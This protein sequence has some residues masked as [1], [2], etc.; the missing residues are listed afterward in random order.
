MFPNGDFLRL[1]IYF[2]LWLFELLEPAVHVGLGTAGSPFAKI[3]EDHF[4]GLALI[5]AIDFQLRLPH[6]R[7]CDV[8][9]LPILGAGETEFADFEFCGRFGRYG[10]ESYNRHKQSNQL[11]TL[12][13]SHEKFA[14]GF[15]AESRAH[16][17][18]HNPPRTIA[19]IRIP[20]SDQREENPDSTT[21]RHDANEL[22]PSLL[23]LLPWRRGPG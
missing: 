15:V 11:W 4:C 8:H 7:A 16:C 20:Y 10:A 1:G 5:L 19:K 6:G 14:T 3:V 9:P 18:A 22:G 17:N 13:T 21:A 23:P 2:L 12:N